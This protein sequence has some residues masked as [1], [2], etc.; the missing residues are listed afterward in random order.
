[1]PSDPQA[2]VD[3]AFIVVFFIL[4]GAGVVFLLAHLL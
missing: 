2:T 4:M 3:R 1:M